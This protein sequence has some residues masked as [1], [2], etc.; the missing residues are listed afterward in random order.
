MAVTQNQSARH[1]IAS[2]ASAMWRN[3]SSIN[4]IFL[5]LALG[6]TVL[7]AGMKWRVASPYGLGPA[8]LAAQRNR[9]LP[10]KR[11][12]HLVR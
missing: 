1:I 9:R 5:K 10:G 4:E 3:G 8:Y 11:V 6:D 12:T 7:G 2:G